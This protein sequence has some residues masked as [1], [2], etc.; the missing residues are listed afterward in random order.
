[1]DPPGDG[2]AG[3]FLLIEVLDRG[4]GVPDELAE[5][6]F[7]PF[8]RGPNTSEPGTGLG[9]ATAAAAI[10]AHHG[11]LGVER[12]EGGGSRFWLRVPA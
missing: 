11:T 10:R 8:L 9:L 12:R 5:R 1:M 3:M 7:Q 6:L 4:P 2:E